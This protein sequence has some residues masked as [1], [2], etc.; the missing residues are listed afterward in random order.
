[1]GILGGRPVLG[2][3]WGIGVLG[4]GVNPGFTHFRG[5][6]LVLGVWFG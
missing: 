1:V 6:F 5:A 4:G 2:L 3:F